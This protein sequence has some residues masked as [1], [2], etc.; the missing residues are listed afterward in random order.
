MDI[1]GPILWIF[2]QLEKTFGFGLPQLYTVEKQTRLAFDSFRIFNSRPVFWIQLF[3]QLF[4]FGQETIAKTFLRVKKR[5]DLGA[6]L[7]I[8]LVMSD[9]G[10]SADN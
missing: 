7:T 9:D 4:R 5:F 1:D 6:K 8:L 10:R 3:Q 2:E